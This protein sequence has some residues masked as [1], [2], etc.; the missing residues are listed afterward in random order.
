MSTRVHD[1]QTEVPSARPASS[2]STT[3]KIHGLARRANRLPYVGVDLPV[4]LHGEHNVGDVVHGDAGAR[5][6]RAHDEHVARSV[7]QDGL[8]R[9]IFGMHARK[10]EVVTKC[11]QITPA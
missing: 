8:L 3:S 10:T 2:S 9:D 5:E 11:H 7:V 4:D 1:L 6:V